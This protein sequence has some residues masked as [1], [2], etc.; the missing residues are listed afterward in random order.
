MPP[1]ADSGSLEYLFEIGLPE[2]TTLRFSLRKAQSNV[3][4]ACTE[5]D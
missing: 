5:S 2:V 4:E 1:K 3:G